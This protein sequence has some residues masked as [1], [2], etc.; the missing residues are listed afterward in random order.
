MVPVAL[1]HDVDCRYK[2]RGLKFNNNLDSRALRAVHNQQ[3]QR[4]KRD[5]VLK[6]RRQIADI[7]DSPQV[8]D[9]PKKKGAADRQAELYQKGCE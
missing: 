4:E 9:L 1:K 6:T 8:A 2:K 7:Q 5:G 3:R